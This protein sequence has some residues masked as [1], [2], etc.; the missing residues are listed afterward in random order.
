VPT[1]RIDDEVYAA[2]QQR[3]VPFVDTPN[4]VLRRV[5]SLASRGPNDEATTLVKT[6]STRRRLDIEGPR[7]QTPHEEYRLPILRT[8]VA[9]GGSG[10]VAHVIRR[11]GEGMKAT[12]TRHDQE[13]IRSG[14]VRWEK[15]AN[16]ERFDMVREGLLKSDSPRG[17]WAISE[18]GRRYLEEHG[19]RTK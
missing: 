18:K 3:G 19:S 9:L 14:M 2:L 12:L 4:D 1:I 15:A 8:L 11:V 6:S 5:L 16:W 17:V 7:R 13:D 10:D